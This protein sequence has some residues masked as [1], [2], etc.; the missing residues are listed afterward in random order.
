MAE[1]RPLPASMRR[2]RLARHARWVFGVLAV[3]GLVYRLV[4]L[5]R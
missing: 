3:A 5:Y 4:R 2:E 1:R